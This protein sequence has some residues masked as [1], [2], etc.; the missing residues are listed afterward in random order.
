V[1]GVL[2]ATG[3]GCGGGGGPCLSAAGNNRITIAFSKLYAISRLVFYVGCN[4]GNRMDGSI[5]DVQ[6]GGSLPLADFHSI[7]CGESVSISETLTNRIAIVMTGGGGDD[8]SISI[9]EIEV[10][11]WS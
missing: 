11:G 10:Y 9:E 4:D 2:N 7:G 8:F 3:S 6:R 1:D 5:Y